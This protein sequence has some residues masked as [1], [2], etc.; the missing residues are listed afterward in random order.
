M[1]IR[2]IFPSKLNIKSAGTTDTTFSSARLI[3]PQK[4]KAAANTDTTI[5]SS[6]SS[7]ELMFPTKRF[8][9]GPDSTTATLSG[10][11]SSPKKKA[12]SNTNTDTL[13][14]HP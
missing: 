14:P 8:M 5:V 6:S 1:S 11:A 10:I 3:I 13:Y 9:T 7:G 2:L 4:R 12:P